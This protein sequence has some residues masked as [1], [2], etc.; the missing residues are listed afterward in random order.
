MSVVSKTI[1]TA[2]KNET[3]SAKFFTQSIL[4]HLPDS[5]ARVIDQTGLSVIKIMDNT[6]TASVISNVDVTERNTLSLLQSH[7]KVKLNGK[8]P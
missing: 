4:T 3:L 8:N 5:F 7:L 2:Y 1:Q 6:E